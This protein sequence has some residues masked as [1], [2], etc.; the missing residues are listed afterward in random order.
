LSPP[1]RERAFPGGVRSENADYVGAS[2]FVANESPTT[3][4]AKRLIKA[5]VLFLDFLIL[6]L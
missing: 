2:H 1:D 3:G 4:P 6:Y 5:W